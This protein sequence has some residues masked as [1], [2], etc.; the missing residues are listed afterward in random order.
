MCL[1]CALGLK[2]AT[3]CCIEDTVFTHDTR[4]LLQL[5]WLRTLCLSCEAFLRHPT[6]SAPCLAV[7]NTEPNPG[8]PCFNPLTT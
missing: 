2:A 7:F 4:C 3:D 1:V 6:V 8:Q 5:S